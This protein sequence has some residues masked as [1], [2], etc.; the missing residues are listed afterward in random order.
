MGAFSIWHFL[1]LFVFIGF[2][3]ALLPIFIKPTGRN[4]FGAS[5]PAQSFGGAVALC[6]GKYVD[7]NG[8]GSRSEYWWFYLAAV[9]ASAAAMAVSFS[10]GNN[11]LLNLVSLALLLPSLAAGARRLHDINR[12]GW[13]QLLY[14]TGFGWLALLILFAQ[15]SQR[16]DGANVF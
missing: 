7:F 12:S 6:M 10:M 3:P 5:A 11:I 4:R 1:I 13:W 8:R 2:V 14:F 16:D 15:P 9:L